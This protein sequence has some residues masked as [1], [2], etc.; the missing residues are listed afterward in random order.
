MSIKSCIKTELCEKHLKLEIAK[1]D[2]EKP[3]IFRG[4]T[5]NKDRE[6]HKS[7]QNKEELIFLMSE[8]QKSHFLSKTGKFMKIE[9][10]L[11]K[12]ATKHRVRLNLQADSHQISVTG[13]AKNVS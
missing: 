10:S 13:S 12:V 4:Q 11:T 7:G 6:N 8:K 2:R 3:G 5:L 9:P 1:F